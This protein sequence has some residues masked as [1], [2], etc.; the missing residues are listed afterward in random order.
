MTVARRLSRDRTPQAVAGRIVSRDF[1]SFH[2]ECA[3]RIRVRAAR[4]DNAGRGAGARRKNSRRS[5]R[6]LILSCT[7]R[8][9]VVKGEG[10]QQTSAAG[11]RPRPRPIAFPYRDPPGGIGGSS[12]VPIAPSYRTH[13]VGFWS[14]LT[15]TASTARPST[16]RSTSIREPRRSSSATTSRSTTS[17]TGPPGPTSSRRWQQPSTSRPAARCSSSPVTGVRV[18]QRSSCDCAACSIGTPTS[19]ST[20]TSRTTSTPSC[21]WRRGRSSSGS[22]RVSWTTAR[23]PGSRGRS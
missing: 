3:G 15:P 9:S 7:D 8:R 17:P 16:A 10:A 1:G 18:R 21:R 22:R 20:G 13:R 6:L 11:R 23:A 19:P 4:I 2:D 14:W 12:P 5:L